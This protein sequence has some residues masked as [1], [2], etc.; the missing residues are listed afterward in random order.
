MKIVLVIGFRILLSFILP[1]L[2]HSF[3]T[4]SLQNNRF[5]TPCTTSIKGSITEAAEAASTNNN[6]GDDNK[7]D[8][9][10]NKSSSSS[11]DMNLFNRRDITKNIITT[12]AAVVSSSSFLFLQPTKTFAQE[13]EVTSNPNSIQFQRELCLPSSNDSTTANTSSP[14]A[15]K[16]KPFPLASFGLQIYD[17]EKA[18][19]LTLTALELGYRN[20]F[21]SVL[22]GNQKGFAKAIRDSNIPLSEL[23]ICG[24][25]LSN[26]ANGYKAAYTKTFKGCEENLAI[27]SQYG[28][29]PKLDMIMLDYP[30][31]DDD[32][33]RGQWD[34]FQNFQRLGYVDDLAVSNF[35]ARQLDCILVKENNLNLCS[36]PVCNQLPFSIA[37]HPKRY[38]EENDV[39]RG[40]H[41]QSWSPLSSTLPKY[42]DVLA[43]IGMKYN[44]SAAQVGLR[45]IVQSGASYCVQSQKA[46]HFKED[47][48]V[49]DFQLSAQ[50]MERLDNLEPPRLLG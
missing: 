19:K 37:N 20:F 31:L 49:F 5:Y 39:A 21:A 35:D 24:T 30:A 1:L 26:R 8:V 10:V 45:W 12:S 2:S 48:D 38:M 13:N 40:I 9:K 46:S 25:V 22:A 27:M 28:N 32:S 16:S 4:I 15:T 47:L 42:K 44:K 34:A 11:N 23:Y 29:I 41:V 43:S 50:D 33:I 14:V 7:D 3:S 18:Y 36:K 6:D 17:N